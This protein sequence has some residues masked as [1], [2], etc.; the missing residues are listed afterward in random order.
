MIT[1][2]AGWK[3]S[4]SRIKQLRQWQTNLWNSS[5][6][7]ECQNSC[8][9]IRA[10]I[11]NLMLV[12]NRGSLQYP[13]GSKTRTTPYHP[14]SDGLVERQNRTLLSMLAMATA[15]HPF[16]MGKPPTRA[17]HGLQYKRSANQRIYTLFPNVWKTSEDT[18]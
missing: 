12:F 8:T 6:D 16:I 5:L 13:R 17:L 15:N 14:Q 1:S 7:S 4:V 2:H 18:N 3:H 9:Q 10:E 11:L